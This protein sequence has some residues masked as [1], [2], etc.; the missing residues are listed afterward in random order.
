MPSAHNISNRTELFLFKID[1]FQKKKTDLCIV[2]IKLRTIFVISSISYFPGP[3]SGSWLKF[4][5]RNSLPTKSRCQ[6]FLGQALITNTICLAQPRTDT[7]FDQPRSQTKVSIYFYS[8]FKFSL[9]STFKADGGLCS[10]V[11]NLDPGKA[12]L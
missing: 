10:V 7:F 8:F 3:N 2:G 5:G 12:F 9:R 6:S 1:I 11:Q 4:S